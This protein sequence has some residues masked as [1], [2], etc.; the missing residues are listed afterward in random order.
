VKLRNAEIA[1]SGRSYGWKNQKEFDAVVKQL[2]S[3]KAPAKA[4]PAAAP[5]KAPKGK[6]KA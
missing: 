1:K 3:E 6:A 5:A 4:E 2:K